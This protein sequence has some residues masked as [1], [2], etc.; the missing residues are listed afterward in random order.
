[1]KIT[2]VKQFYSTQLNLLQTRKQELKKQLEDLP[3]YGQNFD[4]ADISR[5]LRLVSEN[6]DQIRSGLDQLQLKEITAQEAEAAKQQVKAIEEAAEELLKCMEIARRIADGDK[7]PASDERKLLEYDF[8]M[9]MSAKN[10]AM[11][12]Q[13]TDPKEYDS[14]WKDEEDVQEDMRFSE[15]GEDTEVEIR[16]SESTI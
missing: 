1:M 15:E 16:L 8:K 12:N 7:V 13:K 9:Y 5:E 6:Y 11:V 3:A 2:N 10:L 4:R 14:L